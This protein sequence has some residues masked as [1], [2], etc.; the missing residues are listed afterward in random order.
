MLRKLIFCKKFENCKNDSR[1]T[2]GK[3]LIQFYPIKEE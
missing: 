3:L 2:W 1:K